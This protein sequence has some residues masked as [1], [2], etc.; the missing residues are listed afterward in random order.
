MSSFSPS[1]VAAAA[2]TRP[3]TDDFPIKAPIRHEK[4][5]LPDYGMAIFNIQGR[6]YKVHRHFF[7]Q[8]SEVFKSMFDCPSPPGGN[9]DGDSDETPIYLPEV[10]CAEFEALLDFFYYGRKL[11]MRNILRLFGSRTQNTLKALPVQDASKRPTSKKQKEKGGS[12]A[13][14]PS[15]GSGKLHDLLSISF[16]YAFDSIISE[17]VAAIDSSGTGINIPIDP[18]PKVLLALKHDI[19]K[20]W[21]KPA[22]QELVNRSTSLTKGEIKSLG[23]NKAAIISGRREDH[24]RA[25]MSYMNEYVDTVVPAAFYSAD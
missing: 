22:F 2:L 23:P 14:Q 4:Y 12:G 24:I 17:V 16:R 19:L 3:G 10:T 7:I 18:V 25:V 20:H 8:E 5:Y 6:L 21:L 11:T 1:T 9:Q 13:P 15:Q